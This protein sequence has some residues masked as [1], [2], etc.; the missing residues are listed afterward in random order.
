MNAIL[1]LVLA[2]GVLAVLVI[3]HRAGS[4]CMATPIG[5]ASLTIGSFL[6]SAAH[7]AG[8]VLMPALLPMCAA[9]S[10]SHGITASGSL[11]AMLGAIAIHTAAMLATTGLMAAGVCRWIQSRSEKE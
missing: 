10:S 8:L 6:M 1:M 2:G 11:I 7:G 9:K 3:T 4:K 5:Y